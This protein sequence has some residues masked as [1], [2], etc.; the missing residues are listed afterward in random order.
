M[1]ESDTP[2]PVATPRSSPVRR[3]EQAAVAAA[4][5]PTLSASEPT[6]EPVGTDEA[7]SAEAAGAARAD[8]QPG[9][10]ETDGASAE[11]AGT[12][13]QAEGA[14]AEAAGAGAEGAG[15]STQA[16]GASA[17]AA[18]ASTGSVG[19]SAGAEGASVE[20]VA[21]GASAEAETASAEAALAGGGEERV[22]RGGADREGGY[23]ISHLVDARLAAGGWYYLVEWEGYAAPERSWEPHWQVLRRGDLELETQAAALRDA[24]QRGARREAAPLEPGAH[25]WLAG[26]TTTRGK[27]W[28][29]AEGGGVRAVVAKA[30]EPGAADSAARKA[31]VQLQGVRHNGR[32]VRA[33]AEHVWPVAPADPATAPPEYDEDEVG[34][35]HEPSPPP[36]PRRGPSDSVPAAADGP[37]VVYAPVA[38]GAPAADAPAGGGAPAA[39]SAPPAANAPAADAPAADAVCA[40]VACPARCC[41]QVFGPGAGLL[42]AAALHSRAKTAAG[43]MRQ[44]VAGHGMRAPDLSYSNMAQLQVIFCPFCEQPQACSSSK[45]GFKSPALNCNTAYS[46]MKTCSRRAGRSAMDAFND[47]CDR[48]PGGKAWARGARGEGPQLPGPAPP[49]LLSDRGSSSPPPRPLAALAPSRAPQGRAAGDWSGTVPTFPHQRPTPPLPPQSLSQ[50]EQDRVRIRAARR[51]RGLQRS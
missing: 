22:Q 6:P 8:Q 23:H 5:T 16:E 1:S 4:A 38:R 9:R 39:A 25:A 19:A 42:G 32:V 17:E 14:S 12:G 11:G 40:P 37:A 34:S 36:S 48:Q 46:H 41:S 10:A 29:K 28:L 24:V 47:V 13:A 21:E 27:A 31:H 33:S 30:P 35:L 2:E 18:G 15:A 43:H 49:Q 20:A 50:Y 44:A 3:G 7:G 26:L 45:E 51:R